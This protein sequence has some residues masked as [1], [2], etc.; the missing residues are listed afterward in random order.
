MDTDELKLLKYGTVLQRIATGDNDWFKVIYQDKVAYMFSTNLKKFE[1]D[2]A[3]MKVITDLASSIVYKNPGDIEGIID[4][5]NLSNAGFVSTIEATESDRTEEITDG[6]PH[7]KLFYNFKVIT[8]FE[9]SGAVAVKY[10]I[11]AE[12]I[13]SG[14]EKGWNIESVNRTYMSDGLRYREALEKNVK[15][16]AAN[17]DKYFGDWK[18]DLRVG[19]GIYVWSNGD[20]FNV[21]WT[22]SNVKYEGGLL[23]LGITKEQFEL[24]KKKLGL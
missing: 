22:K 5:D 19:K 3:E 4:P 1:A 24:I 21:V 12:L 7:G 14:K 18:D 11:R 8:K 9:S 20:V 17:G 23:K 6:T 15:Y 10:E 16:S 13:T 2:E